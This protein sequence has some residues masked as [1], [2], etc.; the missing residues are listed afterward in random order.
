MRSVCAAALLATAFG[1]NASARAADL[2]ATTPAPAAVSD[3]QFQATFYGWASGLDGTTGVRGLPPASVDISAGDVLK[4]LDGALMGAFSAQKGAWSFV[5]DLI[6]ARLSGGTTVGRRDGF[7]AELDLTQVTASGLVGYRLPL[8][9]PSNVEL[10]ATAGFRY[11]HI[12]ADFDLSSVDLPIGASAG[13]TQQ[14]IDP[15]VGLMLNYDITDKWFVNAIAD[16][17]GFG[18]SSKITAQGFV[19]LGYMWTPSVSTAIGYRA[20]YTDYENDGFV[21]DLTQHGAFMSLAYHF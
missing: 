5:G 17:G 1:W 4:T 6:Y 7:Q 13:G 20:I 21:Y 16:V 8:G 9:L 3:W 10:S 11:Q 15:T 14:W 12:E 19:T 2:G 18:V